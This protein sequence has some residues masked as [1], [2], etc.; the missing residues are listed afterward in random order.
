MKTAETKLEKLLSQKGHPKDVSEEPLKDSSKKTIMVV[1][2]EE[3]MRK[4]LV[5][6]L[7]N[8]YDI[9]TAENGAKAIELFNKNDDL[10]HCVVMD[11]KMPEMDGFLASE[12]LKKNNPLLPIIMLTAQQ[13]KHDISEVV[14]YKFAGY[15]TKGDVE[16]TPDGKT[17][18]RTLDNLKE[19]LKVACEKYTPIFKEEPFKPVAYL[20]EKLDLIEFNKMFDP[21]VKI[22]ISKEMKEYPLLINGEQVRTNNAFFY[23]HTD[24]SL[25]H[26][27][28]LD[29]INRLNDSKISLE[30]K[31]N[32]I[33]EKD[34]SDVIHSYWHLTGIKEINMAAEAADKAF[35]ELKQVP[36]EKRID[37]LVEIGK[38]ISDD[39]DKW[40]TISRQDFHDARTFAYELDYVRSILDKSHLEL[41]VK[42]FQDSTIHYG[43]K[44]TII[45]REPIGA[46]VVNTPPNTGFTMGTNVFADLFLAGIPAVYKPSITA[47]VTTNE[48]GAFFND[49]LKEYNMPPGIVNMIC[50]DSEDIVSRLMY[51]E[52][53]KGIIHIGGP[54]GGRAI[55][56]EYSDGGKRIALEMNGSDIVGFLEDL[57]EQ[58]FVYNAKRAFEERVHGAAGQFCVG[59]KRFLVPD[60]Y[61][62]LA[63]EIAK[64]VISKTNPGLMSDKDTSLI[65]VAKPDEHLKQISDYSKDASVVIIKT[66]QRVNWEGKVDPDGEFVTPSIIYVKNPETN[67]TFLGEELFGPAIQIALLKDIKSIPLILDKSNYN[68]RC[69]FHTNIKSNMEYL[70]QN[71]K[72]GGIAFNVAHQYPNLGHVGGGR[73]FSCE[74]PNR[75]ARNFATDFT[76]PV[77]PRIV[78]SSDNDLVV[79]TP[80]EKTTRKEKRR[81]VSLI[82]TETE[83]DINVGYQVPQRVKSYTFTQDLLIVPKASFFDQVIEIMISKIRVANG[84]KLF[85]PGIGPAMFA[86][87]FMNRNLLEHFK[88]IHLVGA[89]ISH[90]MLEY[91]STLLNNLYEAKGN[92]FKITAEF[93]SGIN[94]INEF[95]PFY[96]NILLDNESFHS[97][98]ASQFEHYC[99]NGHRSDLAQK[100]RT[101]R[102]PYSTKHEF[103]QLCYD[104]L[105]KGGIYFTIDDRLGETHEEHATI[106][107][108]WDTFVVDQSTDQNVLEQIAQK[109]PDLANKLG[110]K[111]NPQFGTD[112]LLKLASETRVHR[113]NLCNEEI[114]PLTATLND[115]KGIYGKDNVS[116]VLHTSTMTHP[117]FYLAWAVKK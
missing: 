84:L 8:E 18:L 6:S 24:F 20:K 29:Q 2:D 70:I 113:R 64:D 116:H 85:E 32:L 25:K 47:A 3:P 101:N 104:L 93:S 23:L 105:E 60:K 75:G 14:D 1:D 57:T 54:E 109:S 76:D 78:T 112:E 48:L 45:Y 90:G 44:S 65:P 51:N 11:A 22:G 15:V 80:I 92:S 50:G 5:D 103:R 37:V 30:E 66:A 102:T 99:P 97:I 111:Y 43:N 114:E 72:T 77:I 74:R 16:I 58:D 55:Q 9:I 7:S 86:E 89:D 106:C 34:W 17:I 117:G 61:L 53:I 26:R 79:Q 35:E 98:I 38:R 59:P 31:L 69:S 100:Y 107:K 56:Q 62:N 88:K 42:Q 108:A 49:I 73:A 27:K 63:I 110:K 68:L 4:G 13:D 95:D 39:R 67:D 10:V 40:E 91:A 87:H 96:Q 82:K 19:K 71:C 81:I 28:A 115:L 46:V 41:K 83:N 21:S 36:I 12:H 52:N 94:C 33:N